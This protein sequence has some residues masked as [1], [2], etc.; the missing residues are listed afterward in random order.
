M[1]ACQ[2]RRR[3]EDLTYVVPYLQHS[4]EHGKEKFDTRKSLRAKDL[5]IGDLVLLRDTKLRFQHI[6]HLFSEGTE[7]A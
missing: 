2:L 4:R 3:D 5:N 7:R 1:R 6:W